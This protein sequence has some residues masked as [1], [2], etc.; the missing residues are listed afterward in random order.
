M[1]REIT[2]KEIKAFINFGD[3][4]Y[5][6]DKNY[7]PYINKDLKKTLKRLVFFR[8]TYFAVCHFDKNNKVDGRVLLTIG[9]SKQ[10]KSDKCGYFSHIE[11]VENYDV[12][13]E[14]MDFSLNLLKEKGADCTC[15]TFFHHDPD[16]RRGILI[17]N[18]DTFPMLFTSYNKPYY[19][20]YFEKYGFKKLIDALEY[21]YSF[22]EDK[23]KA[24]KEKGE[25]A[26][27][28]NDI[29]ID[30]A[31]LKQ[32]DRE[33]EAVHDIMVTA[34]TSINFEEVISKEQIKKIFYSFK[35]FL[36]PD[37]V[38]FARTNKDNRPIGFTFALPN[39][40]EVIKK[41]N[42]KTNIFSLIKFAIYKKRITGLRAMLQYIIPEYQHKGISKALYNETRKSIEKNHITRV[43][44]GTIMEN[45]DKS[46][47]LVV[48]AGGVRSKTY[49]IYYKE[50]WF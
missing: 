45:N 23:M 33:I 25:Q 11:F 41:M 40:N 48:S 26:L 24:V 42:G 7:I 18:F 5:K 17:D 14:L 49:R 19:K 36:N 4:L 1:I 13:K 2:E 22:K 29:H 10:L 20:D 8:K 6:G 21:E 47:G 15:G 31:D 32:L 3:A 28:D 50:L 30:K 37:Y 27:I 35:S 43:G 34:S 16:N 9:K 38:F 44:L 39:Y 46:N 12:F